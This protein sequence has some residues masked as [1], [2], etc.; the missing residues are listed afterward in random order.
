MA[1]LLVDVLL[2]RE[3]DKGLAYA[4]AYGA[5]PAKA[6]LLERIDEEGCGAVFGAAL[7]IT[8]RLHRTV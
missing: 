1:P 7:E 5:S 4:L 3:Q 6:G 2:L 8:N